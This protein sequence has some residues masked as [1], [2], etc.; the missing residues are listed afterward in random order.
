MVDGIRKW[1]GSLYSVE[2]FE[3]GCVV[4]FASRVASFMGSSFP[5]RGC[6]PLSFHLQ[7]DLLAVADKT[8]RNACS[9]AFA[10]TCFCSRVIP[11][12]S[13]AGAR[14]SCSFHFLRVS[15]GLRAASSVR[16][17][18]FREHCRGWGEVGGR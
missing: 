4:A 11:M 3:A 17:A 16:R 18:G 13:G 10:C 7:K 15:S 14:G 5:L 6:A 2:L 8:E 1:C 12:D 9:Q